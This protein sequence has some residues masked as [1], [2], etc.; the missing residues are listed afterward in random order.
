MSMVRYGKPAPFLPHTRS[1]GLRTAHRAPARTAALPARKP[2][3][4]HPRGPGWLL[5]TSEQG[6]ELVSPTCR[7][8]AMVTL[9]A[10]GRGEGQ[11]AV[12]SFWVVCEL[13]W[14]LWV[15]TLWNVWKQEA[16][17]EG[18]TAVW[19]NLRLVSTDSLLSPKVTIV[20]TSTYN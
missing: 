12:L 17:G 14:S 20:S 8:A 1:L 19:Q 4:S 3:P 16:L 2:G 6:R 10:V 13:G 7:A 5:L 9:L 18:V 15:R 11:D